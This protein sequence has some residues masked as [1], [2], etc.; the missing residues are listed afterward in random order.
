MK[1]LDK[2]KEALNT[3]ITACV[4]NQVDW[5]SIEIYKSENLV[6]LMTSAAYNILLAQ[7]DLVQSIKEGT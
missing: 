2:I 7:L 6:S 5:S 1:E 4:E 3:A